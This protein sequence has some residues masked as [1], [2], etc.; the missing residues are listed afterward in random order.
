MAIDNVTTKERRMKCVMG[1]N[2]WLPNSVTHVWHKLVTVGLEFTTKSG[3]ANRT[4]IWPLYSGRGLDNPKN[5]DHLTVRSRIFICLR[6]TPLPFNKLLVFYLESNHIY[7]PLY[8]IVRGQKRLFQRIMYWLPPPPLHLS[9]SINCLFEIRC[10]KK[11]KMANNLA[12]LIRIW[13]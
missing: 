5:F 8:N 13:T 6:A 2:L 11:W 9:A 3:H 7:Q 4:T 1:H 10:T 12:K